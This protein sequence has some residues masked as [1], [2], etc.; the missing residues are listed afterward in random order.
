ML[1]IICIMLYIIFSDILN[2]SSILSV[3]EWYSWHFPELKEQVKDNFM[4]AQCAAFIKDKSALS[5]ETH[6]QG[7]TEITGDET[8]ALGLYLLLVILLVV[9]I[10]VVIAIIISSSCSY[11]YISS[12]I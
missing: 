7:L 5:E 6:L 9:F 11:Y 8:V 2:I 4:F 3:R 12:H 1:Y 10:I